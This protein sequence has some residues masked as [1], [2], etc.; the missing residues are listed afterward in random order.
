MG[1]NS[2][3]GEESKKAK[4]L[5]KKFLKDQNLYDDGLFLIDSGKI[6]KNTK[7]NE[8]FNNCEPILII[9]LNRHL[10]SLKD[11]NSLQWYS[12][13]NFIESSGYRHQYN[14]ENYILIYF[15]K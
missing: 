15:C 2:K 1:K 4:K 13:L 9:Y 11:N 7:K 8:E 6:G 10:V 12:F 14:T 3:I 5:L